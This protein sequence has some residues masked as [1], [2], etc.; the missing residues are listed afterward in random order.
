MEQEEDKNVLR[1]LLH[2]EEEASSLVDGAQ[3]EANRR[4]AEA[5]KQC[6]IQFDEKY[7][8]EVER[9]E[10]AHNKLLD[11]IKEDYRKQLDAYR[12]ELVSRS[13][14]EAAFSDLA[15]ELFLEG[16]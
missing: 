5:E 7:S 6:R 13:V 2:L 10:N 3:A 8:A 9:L 11:D 14:N 4:L 16:K 1:H 15:K 12:S